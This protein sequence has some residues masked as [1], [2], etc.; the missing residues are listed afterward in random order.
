MPIYLYRNAAGLEIEQ[1]VNEN[2]PPEALLVGGETFERVPVAP[3]AVV[4]RPAPTLG[5][6]VMR[7]YREEEIR[8]GA[9]FHTALR[10]EDIKRAWANDAPDE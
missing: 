4:G 2:P 10:P 8:H 3:F 1:L 7:G 6:E 5:T 9:R